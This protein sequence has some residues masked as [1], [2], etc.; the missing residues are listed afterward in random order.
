MKKIILN[1]GGM[2][3]SACSTGLEKYLKKQK[4]ILSVSV[5][6]VMAQ[7][8]IEYDASLTLTDIEEMIKKAG[9]QSLGTDFDKKNTK[10]K[11]EKNLLIL[12]SILS[13]L[14]LY[15]S[16]SHMVHLPVIPF[17]HMM[18]HPLR[19]A[20]CLLLLTLFFL[21]YGFEILKSGFQNF[22]HKTPNMDTLVSIGVLASFFYSVFG[23]FMILFGNIEYVEKLYFESACIVIYFIKL[24]RYIDQ[25]NK[26]KTKE[27]IQE[28]VQITPTKAKKKMKNGF[29]EVTIDEIKKGDILI[30]NPGDKIA[31][32][33]IV[34]NGVSHVNESFITGESL[35]VKKIKDEK[36]VAG[37]FNIDGSIEYQA[38]RIGKDSTISEI[39]RLVV[40]ATNTKAPIARIADQVS[41]VFVPTIILLAI[42]TFF[43]HLIL[44]N[45]FSICFNYFV[46]VLVVACPCA[47]GLSTPLAMVI[48]EGMCA[49]KGILVKSNEILENAHKIDTVVFDKTGTLTYGNLKIHEIYTE[50][51]QGKL[52]K[53]V[54]SI[55]N[56]S[57][58]PIASAFQDI[59]SL[60]EV[61]SFQ[62]IEG[63][64]I[65]GKIEENEYFVG[66]DKWLTNNKIKNHYSEIA[67]KLSLEGNS[68]IY[69]VENQKLIALIGVKDVIREE[70]LDVVKELKKQ[71]KEIYMLTGDNEQTAFTIA[72]EIGIKKVI[73]NVLP[74]DK[75]KTIEKLMA[76][77]KVMMIG[78]GIN[79]AP[80]LAT[81]TI[82]IS[83]SSGTDIASNSADVVLMNNQLTSIV[84]LMIISKK[85]IRN[86]KE[87]L[88]WAFF[89]N[90]A[91][92]PIAMG[93]FS[94][95]NITMNP[96]IAGFAMTISSLTV[97]LNALRLRRTKYVSKEEKNNN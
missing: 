87:N 26:N 25:T 2:S 97:M 59:K 52:L 83:L 1:I 40:E 41:G 61:H 68:L 22:I 20:V 21:Y 24:G 92:I 76:N 95:W 63:F 45:E 73:A 36:V 28:L 16:M 38:T 84:E 55:E 54:A 35:P 8:S 74:K 9:F 77:H 7:A 60:L 72:N 29:E 89:Y 79:D 86:I 91:M 81:S 75:A 88:F 53:I 64:G 4:G 30:C 66:N 96:M 13:I 80:S 10:K 48:S 90:V 11:Q 67:K 23:T 37:S 65:L 57:T 14:V 93:L 49:K 47:L 43:I 78:D 27:A 39:V 69:V 50:M 71:K 3:C 5:N 82:G 85:T 56:K 58:H 12:Y 33:G 70:A 34:I 62:N 15:I 19:Y 6:L 51:E 32:D 94:K 44:G 46:T 42:F 18:Y 31:V 17:L